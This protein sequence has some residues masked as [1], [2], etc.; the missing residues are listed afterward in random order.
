MKAI[1]N[2]FLVALGAFIFASCE[3]DPNMNELDG[4]N[5]VV[6]NYKENA[7]FKQTNYYIADSILVIGD[8]SS[9]SSTQK[10]HYWKKGDPKAD[11]IFAQVESNMKTRGYT[12]VDDGTLTTSGLAIHLS[13]VEDSYYYAAYTYWW[14][15]WYDWYDW[16]YP[17]YPYYPYPVVYSY[18]TGS[19]ILDMID[20]SGPVDI[21]KP[22]IWNAY[23]SGLLTGNQQYDGSLAL[24]AIDQAFAQSPYVS[25]K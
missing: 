11:K 15:Y 3:K 24:E 18:T 1:R 25:N 10:V 16:Y 19:L 21:E 2:L 12:R 13:Y 17:Y 20:L 14:D 7:K 6:T 9:T 8:Q 5:T 4:K 23:M 22:I